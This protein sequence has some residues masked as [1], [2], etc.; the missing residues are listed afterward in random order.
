[1]NKI[2]IYAEKLIEGYNY[3]KKIKC[4]VLYCEN[5]ATIILFIKEKYLTICD[6]HNLKLIED[7]W[8]ENK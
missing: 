5:D 7:P 1:M 3:P 2:N 8:V 6:N 4:D